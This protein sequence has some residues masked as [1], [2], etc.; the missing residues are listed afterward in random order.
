MHPRDNH[1]MYQKLCGCS[2]CVDTTEKTLVTKRSVRDRK[3][4]KNMLADGFISRKAAYICRNCYSIPET[5]FSN[6]NSQ[7]NGKEIGEI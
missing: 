1:E 4:Y 7:T 3:I 5:N 6:Q 2:Q